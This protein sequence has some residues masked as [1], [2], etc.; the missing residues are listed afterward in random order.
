MNKFTQW[1]AGKFASTPEPEKRTQKPLHLPII[2][3]AAKPKKLSRQ[4]RWDNRPPL[5][6]WNNIPVKS[7]NTHTKVGRAR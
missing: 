7:V 2:E 4:D 3:P 1:L 6:K 5:S